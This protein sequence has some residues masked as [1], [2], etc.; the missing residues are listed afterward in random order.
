MP[1]EIEIN[2]RL[3]NEHICVGCMRVLEVLGKSTNEQ[4]NC[5]IASILCMSHTKL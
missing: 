5:A 2:R 4:W 1:K 3:L